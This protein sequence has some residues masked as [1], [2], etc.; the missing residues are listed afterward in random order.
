MVGL[1]L[2]WC[3][4]LYVRKEKIKPIGTPSSRNMA[5]VMAMSNARSMG[6]AVENICHNLRDFDAQKFQIALVRADGNPQAEKIV[7]DLWKHLTGEEI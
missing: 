4:V 5:I 7:R 6:E 2:I 3:T 1:F